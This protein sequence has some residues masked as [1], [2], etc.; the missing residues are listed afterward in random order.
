[1][2]RHVVIFQLRR[3]VDPVAAAEFAEATA[4]F[5]ALAPHA[6]GPARVLTDLGLR[7]EGQYSTEYGLEVLFSDTAAFEAYLADPIHVAY[8]EDWLK[9]RCETWLST[10]TEETA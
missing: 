3:P 2:I 9:P 7:P 4:A 5:A 10:Q 1:M 8:V 6:E